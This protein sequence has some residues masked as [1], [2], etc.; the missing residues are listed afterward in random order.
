MQT[1]VFFP[2]INDYNHFLLT[3]DFRDTGNCNVHDVCTGIQCIHRMGM[4]FYDCGEAEDRYLG[5]IQDK[6]D[7]F[8]RLCQYTGP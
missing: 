6:F 1:K 2:F 5:C 3:K 4:H 7:D 8:N